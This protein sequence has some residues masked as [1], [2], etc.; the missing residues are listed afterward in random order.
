MAFRNPL[1]S[2][3]ASALV[4]LIAGSQI[5]SL[6]VSALTGLHW[7]AYGGTADANGYRVVTHGAGFTPTAVVVTPQSGN[8][9][10]VDQITSTTYR[11]RILTAAGGP[12]A[13][14]DTAHTAILAQ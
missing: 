4:G 6:S 14:L 12:G 5:A 9:F 7:G 11:I 2:L 13:G 3:P 1:G 8:Q 10:G